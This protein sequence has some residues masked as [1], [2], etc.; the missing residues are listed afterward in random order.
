MNVILTEFQKEYLDGLM[1]GDG[2]LHLSKNKDAA[3]NPFLSIVR[4]IKDIEYLRDNL[5]VFQNL[6]TENFKDVHQASIF[7]KR[8]NKNYYNCKFSTRYL[9]C[10]MPTYNRW[11]FNGKKIIPND[12]KLTPLTC[13]IWFYDDGSLE[14]SKKNNGRLKLKLSSHSFTKEENLF[15]IKQMNELLSAN[16]LIVNEKKHSYIVGADLATK[17]L[18]IILNH[19]Y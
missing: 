1:L 15:L 8:T 4:S 13:S 6:C 12:L 18:L 2:N 19:F 17:N 11:Y 10:L 5:K 7:D 16:F 3:K 9:P 14:K